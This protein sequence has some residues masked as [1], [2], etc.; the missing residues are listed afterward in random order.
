MDWSHPQNGL[1]YWTHLQNGSLY[2]THV[3]SGSLYSRMN[4]ATRLTSSMKCME[5]GSFNW[6]HLKFEFFFHLAP[7]CF[8]NT[9]IR[10]KWVN[11][12]TQFS[13]LWCQGSI[14]I[15]QLFVALSEEDEL[16]FVAAV[17]VL[18]LERTVNAIALHTHW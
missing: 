8:L 1:L 5:N 11:S 15:L 18:E 9:E 13:V 4:H 17:F 6:T 16:S 2:W 14:V 12:L 10:Q 3:Q 7:T